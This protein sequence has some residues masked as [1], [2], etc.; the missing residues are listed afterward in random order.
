MGSFIFMA[1]LNLIGLMEIV[2]DIPSKLLLTKITIEGVFCRNQFKKEKGGCFAAHITQKKPLIL[3]HLN[4]KN[5]D[6]L[7]S[8]MIILC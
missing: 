6:L 4:E 3:E 5:L 2:E 1:F 8:N 7:L